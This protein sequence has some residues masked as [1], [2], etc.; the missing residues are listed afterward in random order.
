[1]TDGP[2][3]EILDHPG[4]L[5]RIFELHYRFSCGLSAEI[6]N[7]VR[8]HLDTVDDDFRS[9]PEVKDCFFRILEGKAGVARTL[10]E[11]HGLG[12]LGRYIP[13]FG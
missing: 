13:E 4:G 3:A 12:V 7:F 1:M 8:T 2:E 10:Q 11:M 9:S 5:M 6:R